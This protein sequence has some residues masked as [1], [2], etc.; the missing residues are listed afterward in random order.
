MAANRPGK[1]FFPESGRFGRRQVP[2]DS[3]AT[4]A[5]PSPFTPPRT[6]PPSSEHN[7]TLNFGRRPPQPQTHF[8]PEASSAA[9]LVADD[10]LRPHHSHDHREDRL[11]VADPSLH[12]D[13]RE[14][15]LFAGDDR[16]M[17]RLCSGREGEGVGTSQ[18]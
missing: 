11:G 12:S 16:R 15:P 6:L 9:E 17:S 4:S 5:S 13:A 1:A 14:E 3:V 18:T 2:A 8:V 7:P 10:S